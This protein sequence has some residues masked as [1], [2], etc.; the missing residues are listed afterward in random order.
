VAANGRFRKGPFSEKHGYADEAFRDD[1]VAQEVDLW[2]RAPADSA[3]YDAAGSRRVSPAESVR[4]GEGF[5]LRVPLEAAGGALFVFRPRP[6]AGVV[7]DVGTA[8]PLRPGTAVTLTVTI[9]DD[10][11]APIGGS[12]AVRVSVRDA[13]GAAQDV[14]G[15]YPVSDGVARIPF[16]VPLDASAGRWEVEVKDLTSGYEARAD[17]EVVAGG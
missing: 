9:R 4:E 14:S 5:R 10:N 13:G 3:V 7:A 8:E 1:G 16:G 15:C 17:I 12:S 6:I 11:G 2:V